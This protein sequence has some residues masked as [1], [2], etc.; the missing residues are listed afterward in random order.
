MKKILILSFV[1]LYISTAQTESNLEGIWVGASNPETIFK[2]IL[3]NDVYIAYEVDYS[4]LALMNDESFRIDPNKR[5]AR[6]NNVDGKL[7]IMQKDIV[8]DKNGSVI[9]RDYLN[10]NETMYCLNDWQGKMPT[11]ILNRVDKL[12]GAAAKH[13]LSCSN[14]ECRM[15]IW[16]EGN[17]KEQLLCKNIFCK[18]EKNVNKSIFMED[19]YTSG[20]TTAIFN[21]SINE[22]GR[23]FDIEVLQVKGSMS[24]RNSE[25]YISELL[26][27][28][29]YLP[30][31]INDESY[32][33]TNLRG[34]LSWNYNK[35]D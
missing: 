10:L 25:R 2:L 14:N 35:R 6:S 11:S 28:Q 29:Q 20:K 22:N 34:S 24:K 30:L 1:S 33:I 17:A 9:Y 16:P 3:K 26:K 18:P 23:I 15:K 27:T 5:I 19:D 7:I 13:C 21:Y 8:I 4:T 32:K 31:I 12:R